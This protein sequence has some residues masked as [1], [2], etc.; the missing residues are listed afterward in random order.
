METVEQQQKKHTLQAGIWFYGYQVTFLRMFAIIEW[1]VFAL[2]N[3]QHSS[4]TE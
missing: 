2:L 4:E 1:P 3:Y